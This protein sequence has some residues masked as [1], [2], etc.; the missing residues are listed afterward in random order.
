MT[1]VSV[2]PEIGKHY[3]LWSRDFHKGGNQMFYFVFTG[4]VSEETR[5]SL[6]IAI[7]ANNRIK[8]SI[9]IV[10]GTLLTPMGV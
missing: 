3:H 1:F 8:E 5:Y 7:V 6:V 9:P 4:A 10:T 2:V